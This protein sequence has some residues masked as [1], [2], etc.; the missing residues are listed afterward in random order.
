MFLLYGIKKILNSKDSF[1]R[2][3][4]MKVQ[5]IFFE[6]VCIC[7]YLYMS[8]CICAHVYACLCVCMHVHG[9]DPCVFACIPAPEWVCAYVY[10]HIQSNGYKYK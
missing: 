6:S 2:M 1:K 9:A 10:V 7:L 8:V 4:T 5:I 3:D